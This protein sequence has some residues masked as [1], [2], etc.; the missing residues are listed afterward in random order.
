[1]TQC[2]K[3]RE[4]IYIYILQGKH[5]ITRSDHSES[6]PW[7]L[8][9]NDIT[10]CKYGTEWTWMPLCH[11]DGDDKICPAIKNKVWKDDTFSQKCWL[12]LDPRYTWSDRLA[13]WPSKQPRGH[14]W[15]PV[16][17][18]DAMAKHQSA[19]PDLLLDPLQE[20]AEPGG[21]QMMSKEN[22]QSV[23][24]TTTQS[25]ENKQNKPWAILWREASALLSQCWSHVWCCRHTQ[26]SQIGQLPVQHL[27]APWDPGQ[28][29]NTRCGGQ[30]T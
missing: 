19:P 4:S 13:C 17:A 29:W 20:I 22:I 28:K 24:K 10:V 5:I 12:N 1:M 8:E 9:W 21:I 11:G 7:K 18:P 3:Q 23:K 30:P 6:S 2:L 15:G 26:A 25:T 14:C 27:E 16:S